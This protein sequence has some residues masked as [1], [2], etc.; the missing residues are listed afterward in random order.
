ME[1]F[2]TATDCKNAA[3]ILRKA[4][5][6]LWVETY[7]EFFDFDGDKYYSEYICDCV[8]HIDRESPVSKKITSWIDHQIEHHFGLADWLRTKQQIAIPRY[9]DLM[10]Q[11]DF[12]KLQRTRVAWMDWMIAELEAKA[13]RLK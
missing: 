13:E 6:H 11:E 9:H 10:K 2:T 12:L 4:K 1:F 3:K 8:R 7:F 5:K